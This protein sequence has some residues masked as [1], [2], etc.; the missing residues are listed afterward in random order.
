[1]DQLKTL[2]G[3]QVRVEVSGGTIVQ[4]VLVDV[5]ADIVVIYTGKE[6]LYIPHLHIHHIKL[7]IDPANQISSPFPEIPL[8]EETNISYR[9]TLVNAKGRFVEIYVIGNKTIHGY[10]TSVLNDY[11][12]FYS[13]VYKTMFISLQH[14][15]WLIPYQKSITPYTLGNDLLPVQPTTLA[16]QRSLEEQLKKTEGQLV[17]FD[18]GDHPMKI[19]LLKQ[20]QNNMVE[21]V[22]ANGESVYWKIHHLKIVHFP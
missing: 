10:I 12:V 1:M 7:H 15:K 2:L 9:K 21:L 6:Y 14:L 5:G 19:G 4:G 16:L 18:I 13:P 8:Q 11:F 17:I 22:T 3:K 20:V